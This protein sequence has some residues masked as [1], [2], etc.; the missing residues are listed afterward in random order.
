[1]QEIGGY[2]ELDTYKGDMLHGDGIHLNSGRHA[3][4]YLVYLK[5]IKKLILPK[6]MCDSITEVCNRFS[7]GKIFTSYWNLE[8]RY[9]SIGCD[10]MPD[11][12][13]LAEDEWLYVVDFYGQ[14]GE[15]NIRELK[16]RHGR[17][18]VDYAQ[19]YFAKPLS[20]IDSIYTCR[21]FFG[22]ADGAILYTDIAERINLPTDESYNRMLFL[23]GRYERT[24]SEFYS[25]YVDNNDMFLN[26][27][28]KYMSK[29]TYNLLHAIDYETVKNRRTANF[30]YLHERLQ[31]VNKLS[32][33]I[34]EGAFMYPLYVEGGSFIRKRLQEQ[35]IYIPTLWPDVFDVCNENELEYDMATNILP[36]PVDQ[37]YDEK[38][39]EIIV[40]EIMKWIK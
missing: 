22:V 1:M 23:L 31:G 29:L 7:T 12:L 10:F 14:L 17:I 33:T 18:I 30:K 11:E 27:P 15:A 38:E 13:T 37:R 40:Q 3:L 25:K 39:M 28:V 34:P 36:L 21:K 35:K 20:G 24:A 5:K 8:I 16:K 9:Y 32:L 19:N 4:I 2:I 26:E 6:Y